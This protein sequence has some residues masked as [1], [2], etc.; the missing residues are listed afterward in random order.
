MKGTGTMKYGNLPR[1]DKI[2]LCKV[3]ALIVAF[4]VI[5]LYVI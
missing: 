3:S 5:V 1:T 2:N 4:V